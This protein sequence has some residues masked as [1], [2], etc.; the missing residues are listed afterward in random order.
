MKTVYVALSLTHVKTDTEKGEIR[1]F[2]KWLE[3]TFNVKILL[4]A[5]DTDTWLPKEVGNIYKFDSDRVLSADLMI[6][7]YLSNEGSDGRGGEV[8]LRT[9]NQKPIVAFAKE[10]V[11]VSRYPGDCLKMHGTEIVIFKTFDDMEPTIRKAL[12]SINS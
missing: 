6:V 2:L 3:I 10:G 8:V 11:R 4:W 5:F 1:S 9:T 12:E 7:L